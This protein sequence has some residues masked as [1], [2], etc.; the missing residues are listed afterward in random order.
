V[1]ESEDGHED[2]APQQEGRQEQTTQ[3]KAPSE[4]RVHE[5]RLYLKLLILLAAIAYLI[6]FALQ[7]NDQVDVDFVFAK[8]EI[9]LTWVI[10]ICLAIGLV[11]GVLLSQLYR[12]RRR[13]Q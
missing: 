9:S 7:N 13:R 5:S 2:Q 12:R 6:A 10:L 4:P 11:G 3:E 8:T 1:P